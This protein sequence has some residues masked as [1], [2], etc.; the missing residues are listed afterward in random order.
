MEEERNLKAAIRIIKFRR[1]F[2]ADDEIAIAIA[3][4]RPFLASFALARN[5]I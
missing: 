4:P 3:T 2:P 5:R 1:W